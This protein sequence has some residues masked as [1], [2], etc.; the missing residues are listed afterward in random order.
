M[1]LSYH[2]NTIRKWVNHELL[3]FKDQYY[4][5]VGHGGSA[6]V[7]VLLHFILGNDD[8]GSSY[9]DFVLDDT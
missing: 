4:T 2:A 7:M 5:V 3:T 6:K 8:D 9:L 1:K